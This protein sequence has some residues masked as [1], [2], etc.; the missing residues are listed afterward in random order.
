M[1]LPQEAVLPADVTF[2]MKNYEDG[3]RVV[4]DKGFDV[5][6]VDPEV[7]AGR[8]LD[9]IERCGPDVAVFDLRDI[10]TKDLSRLTVTRCGVV[11]IDDTG[12]KTIAADAVI[13][14]SL[15]EQYRRY[16]DNGMDTEYY[17]GPDYCV[18]AE[19]FSGAVTRET[20]K[21]VER[22]AIF[23]GGSDMAGLT[24]RSASALRRSRRRPGVRTALPRA[25]RR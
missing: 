1:L 2:V 23:M 15:V 12:G 20:R 3:V 9:M 14:A 24:V 10:E 4:T 7:D 22:V 8:E 25:A 6:A 19:E 16:G 5:V 11:V 18:V 21:V 13:N 17:L